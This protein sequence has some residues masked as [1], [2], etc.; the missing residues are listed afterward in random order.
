[1]CRHYF[2]NFLK[3]IYLHRVGVERTTKCLTVWYGR[4]RVLPTLHSWTPLLCGKEVRW[5]V[6]EE[7]YLYSKREKIRR[8]LFFILY[9][10]SFSYY[11]RSLFYIISGVSDWI[12]R[13][14]C[15]LLIWHRKEKRHWPTRCHFISGF[16]IILTN[17]VDLIL[18]SKQ[19]GKSL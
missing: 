17:L 3:F 1:M 15:L 12:Q 6:T 2:C 9:P 19:S 13:T 8:I 14:P 10:V 5:S 4:R 18:G 7:S 11:I 16:Y